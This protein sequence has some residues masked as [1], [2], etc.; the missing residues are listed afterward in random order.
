VQTLLHFAIACWRTAGV[1]LI[2]FFLMPLTT[3]AMRAVVKSPEKQQFFTV[4]CN[5]KISPN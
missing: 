1:E 2:L 5:E 4:R 3:T